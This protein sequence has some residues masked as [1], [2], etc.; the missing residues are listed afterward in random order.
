MNTRIKTRVIITDRPLF[1][2]LEDRQLCSASHHPKHPPATIVDRLK[3][4]AVAAGV[5]QTVLNAAL[6]TAS[7][8]KAKDTAQ[9][10]RIIVAAGLGLP[11]EALKTNLSAKQLVQQTA[12]LGIIGASAKSNTAD[13]WNTVKAKGAGAALAG[14]VRASLAIPEASTKGKSAKQ[15]LNDAANISLLTGDPSSP[16]AWQGLELLKQGKISVEQFA[17]QYA[18]GGNLSK[19][20]KALGKQI[21]AS[22]VRANAKAKRENGNA[23]SNGYNPATD[24]STNKDYGPGGVPYTHPT[25]DTDQAA[26]GSGTDGTTTEYTIN[27][28]THNSDGTTTVAW[29]MSSGGHSASYTT[30]YYPADERGQAYYNITDSDG[31]FVGSGTAIPPSD[32]TTGQTTQST[33]G[34]QA[35]FS[36][37]GSSSNTDDSTNGN[38]SDNG[39]GD[40]DDDSNKNSDDKKSDSDQ[41]PAPAPESAPAD[42]GTT[43][44]DP[45]A[46]STPNPENDNA[47]AQARQQWLSSTPFGQAEM[48][49][50]L[51]VLATTR[52]SNGDPTEPGVNTAARAAFYTSALFSK[53]PMKIDN[54]PGNVDWVDTIPDSITIDAQQLKAIAT[55]AGGAVG[56]PGTGKQP[57]PP[58][59]Q[60]NPVIPVTPPTKGGSVKEIFSTTAIA[61]NVAA[62]MN[63][64]VLSAKVAATVAK[65]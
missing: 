46:S 11:A 12:S 16:R 24:I 13:Y 63:T 43:P 10:E 15:L 17:A 38:G 19:E 60:N 4:E 45:P 56:G 30:T 33:D 20:A 14:E 31:A 1:E 23:A 9:A 18:N 25:Q 39:N 22:V 58:P 64:S 29:T 47:S 21:R 54:N 65:K 42:D 2:P 26:A 55:K 61:S 57:T 51:D 50:I 7:T 34:D 48:K 36:G 6:K 32:S 40:G 59:G 49:S 62:G 3:S 52:G 28:I 37:D 5:D 8:G 41:T 35:I 44:A 53:N 27:T